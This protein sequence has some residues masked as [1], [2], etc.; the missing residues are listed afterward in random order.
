MTKLANQARQLAKHAPKLLA[1]IEAGNLTYTKAMLKLA[2]EK[3][4][5]QTPTTTTANDQVIKAFL[6]SLKDQFNNGQPPPAPAT[7]KPFP[8]NLVLGQ[9]TQERVARQQAE[10]E[11]KSEDLDRLYRTVLKPDPINRSGHFNRNLNIKR[12]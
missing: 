6:T 1:E 8:K 10:F 3:L 5:W 9:E 2:E 7:P 4:D 11:A 12:R